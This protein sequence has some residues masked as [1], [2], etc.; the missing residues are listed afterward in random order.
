MKITAYI[1]TKVRDRDGRLLSRHKKISRS[2]VQGYN[3]A[4]CAQFLAATN[5]SPALGPVPATSGADRNL[6]TCGEAFRIQA[7]VGQT[8]RGIRVGTST[9]AV[10][11]DQYALQAPI[12]H[13]NGAGQMEH[14]A[15]VHNFMGVVGAQCSFW[16]S[17]VFVNNS[18]AQIDVR[19]AGIYMTVYRIPTAG[20]SI[21]AARD[22]ISEDVPDG[23]SVT[24]T[25]TIRIVL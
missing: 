13:G 18:A 15:T 21:M 6:R 2:F 4:V 23:G 19:E 10:A 3:W 8:D 5:P 24:V 1:E 7:N 11:I 22:L 17:R 16:C 14:L 25:Y 9:T 20:E 12:A